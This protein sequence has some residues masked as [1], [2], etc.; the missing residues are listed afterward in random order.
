MV[1][2][3]AEWSSSSETFYYL[4]IKQLYIDSRK[5]IERLINVEVT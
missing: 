5:I 1:I 2:K 4:E 3:K